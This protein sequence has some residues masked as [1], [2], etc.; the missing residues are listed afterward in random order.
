[1]FPFF[2]GV[3]RRKKEMKYFDRFL[4]LSIPTILQGYEFIINYML[5]PG[6]LASDKAVFFGRNCC[7]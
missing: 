5:N 1:M 7:L 2:I 3:Q 6:I 4:Y